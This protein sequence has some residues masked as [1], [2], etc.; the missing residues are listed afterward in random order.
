ML[1][2]DLKPKTR[3]IKPV[4]VI[5]PPTGTIGLFIPSS[6]L[7]FIPRLAL[8]T[9][10]QARCLNPYCHAIPSSPLPPPWPL[11]GLLFLG[12]FY[13]RIECEET[14]VEVVA[15]PKKAT[16]TRPGKSPKPS[17]NSS[18]RPRSKCTGHD[19]ILGCHADHSERSFGPHDGKDLSL[20]MRPKTQ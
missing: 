18:N 10:V 5:T 7:L 6:L 14:A 13:V 16:R 4:P 12:H 19:S 8:G 20:L 17:K 2:V 3:D 11:T 1:V 15:L 9:R